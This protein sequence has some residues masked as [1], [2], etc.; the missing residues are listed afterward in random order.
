MI[1][2]IAGIAL[3]V[4]IYISFVISLLYI[5]FSHFCTAYYLYHIKEF[6]VPEEVIEDVKDKVV[7]EDILKP[8]SFSYILDLVNTY[9]RIV[10]VN[11]LAYCYSENNEFLCLASINDPQNIDLYL[12]K[13]KVLER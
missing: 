1:L 4:F 13:I 9:K 10:V 7:M 3:Q 6:E 2:K 11:R 5:A 8:T 12:D